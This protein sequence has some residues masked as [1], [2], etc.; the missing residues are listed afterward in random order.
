ML[1]GFFKSLALDVF[2]GDC[3]SIIEEFHARRN[4]INLD[5][6][7]DLVVKNISVNQDISIENLLYIANERSKHIPKNYE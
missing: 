5:N 1:C 3:N 6:I 4:N 2:W 7:T